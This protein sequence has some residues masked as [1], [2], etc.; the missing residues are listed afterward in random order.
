MELCDLTYTLKSLNK[1]CHQCA[2]GVYF[3]MRIIETSFFTKLILKL[4][5]DENYRLLQ[6]SLLLRPE[7][8]S[9]IKDSNGLRKIRWSLPKSGKSGGIRVIYYYDKPSSIYML[10]VYKK[11]SQEDLTK[12]QLKILRELVKENLNEK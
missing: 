9:V 10:F 1:I 2:N 8:G 11:N 6:N 12:D 7:A 4:I 5:P 3:C